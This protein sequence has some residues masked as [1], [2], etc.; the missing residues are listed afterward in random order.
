MKKIIL[1]ALSILV[2]NTLSAQQ[3]YK[4]E[5]TDS[6]TKTKSQIYSDTKMFIAEYWKSAQNVIQNDDKENGMILLKCVIIKSVSLFLVTH[7][8]TYQYTIKFLMK[9]GK[10]KIIIDNIY[11]QTVYR[12]NSKGSSY[13]DEYKFDICYN[14]EFPGFWKLG[15]NKENWIDVQNSIKTQLNDIIDSY[16]KYIKQTSSVNTDW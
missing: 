11:P 1:I 7:D 16:D 4:L 14:C 9:N 12:Y 6:I 2:I 15:I 3:E 13:H 8:Y 5:K 10:Y